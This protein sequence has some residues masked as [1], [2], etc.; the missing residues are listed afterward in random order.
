MKRGGE[1][2]S[3]WCSSAHPLCILCSSLTRPLLYVICPSAIRPT[4]S[5]FLSQII[6]CKKKKTTSVSRAIFDYSLLNENIT[7]YGNNI[8]QKSKLMNLQ[9]LQDPLSCFTCKTS[10]RHSDMTNIFLNPSNCTLVYS[11]QVLLRLLFL[12]NVL[13]RNCHIVK[14]HKQ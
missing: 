3:S 13:S 5:H 14:T 11:T 10:I 2:Q 4:N 6:R 12:V 8:T 7:R 9:Y 1:N